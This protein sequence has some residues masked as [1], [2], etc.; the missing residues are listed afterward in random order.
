MICPGCAACCLCQQPG[1]ICCQKIRELKNNDFKQMKDGDTLRHISAGER[2]GYWLTAQSSLQTLKIINLGFYPW[3]CAWVFLCKIQKELGPE[4]DH[5]S[6]QLAP[7]FADREEHKSVLTFCFW[8][9]ASFVIT[10]W[11]TSTQHPPGAGS[12]NFLLV[13]TH[14]SIPS[15]QL[16][17]HCN[18]WSVRSLHFN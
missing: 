17:Y 5:I 13:Q 11:L 16:V 8:N 15:P 10:F 4:Q 1:S 3:K 6:Q 12:F 9:T 7:S 2:R 18:T 14:G